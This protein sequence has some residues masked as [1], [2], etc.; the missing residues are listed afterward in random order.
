MTTHTPKTKLLVAALLLLSLGALQAVPPEL[1]ANSESPLGLIPWPAEL[2]RKSGSFTLD[3]R[4]IIAAP[5]ALYSE[6]LLLAEPLRKATGFPLPIVGP[7]LSSPIAGTILFRQSKLDGNPESYRLSVQPTSVT[8]DAESAAGHFWGTRTL[9]QLLPPQAATGRRA[10]IGEKIAWTVP[11]V[12]ISDRPRFA[13]R[14]FMLDEARSFHGLAAVKRMIDEMAALKLNVFHWH[15]IDSSCWGLEIRS[16]PKLTTTGVNTWN[17]KAGDVRRPG[18]TSAPPRRFYTQEEAR[19]LVEYA[20]RRHVRVIPEVEM[21]GHS[22]AAIYAYPEWQAG[23]AESFDTTKPEVVEAIKAVLDEVLALFPDAV[24]HTGGDEVNFEQWAKAPSIQAAMAAKGLT[25]SAPLQQEFST[26]IAK[27]LAAKGKRM[28]YWADNLEQ[29]PDENSAILQYWRGDPTLIAKAA[30][31]G[32]DIVNSSSGVTYLD[33]NYAGLPLDQVYAFNPIPAGLDEKYH[34]HILGLGAQAWGELMPTIFR[35]DYQ[36]FPRLAAVAEVGWTPQEKKDFH[37]FAGRLKSQERRWDLA[38]IQYARGCERPL[39]EVR[40]EVLRE[41]KIGGWTPEQVGL[42][43]ARHS[44]DESHYQKIDV[45]R[46]M[47][48]PGRYRMAFVPTSGTDGLTV[49][50]VE[51]VEDGKPIASDWAGIWAPSYE[52]GKNQ[53]KD[54][55]FDLWVRSVKPSANYTLR[56]NYYGTKPKDP[57][58]KIPNTAGDIFMKNA[59]DLPPAYAESPDPNLPPSR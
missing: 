6:A 34:R 44:E 27:Y 26:T 3:E 13:W 9:L 50:E 19:E 2:E 15:L 40:E 37:S 7:P 45:T 23:H 28:I 12:E 33:Y 58:Q 41:P 36:I 8:I 53:D 14:A 51:L 54:Y 16:Y 55:V 30:E 4:T 47:S 22:A 10:P 29:I 57:A 24:I 1:Q 17:N 42:A 48:G 56:I 32:F 46:S 35:C 11:C 21:P 5:P 31:R 43:S 52:L 18:D 20:A 39:A 49:R 59:G 38:G 25:K